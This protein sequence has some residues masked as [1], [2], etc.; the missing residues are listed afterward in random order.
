MK[1]LIKF[2]VYSLAVYGAVR[3]WQDTAEEEAKLRGELAQGAAAAGERASQ[4]EAEARDLE[5][6]VNAQ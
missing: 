4:A 1:G 3:L 5:D 6:R 2:C